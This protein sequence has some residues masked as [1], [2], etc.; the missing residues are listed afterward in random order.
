MPIR[1]IFALVILFSATAAA[2]QSSTSSSSSSSAGKLEVSV[3]ECE[4]DNDNFP[5]SF[6]V[7][8]SEGKISGFS[9]SGMTPAP[10]GDTYYSCYFEAKRSDGESNWKGSGDEIEITMK[11]PIAEDDKMFLTRVKDTITLRLEVSPS[12]CGHSSAIA[13][14]I[15]IVRGKKQCRD[16]EMN[17]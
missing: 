17:F 7:E 1:L 16:I 5:Q 2:A 12:N 11:E 10:S 9:Y 14:S 4:A 15:S 13:T 6:S 8:F 3:W